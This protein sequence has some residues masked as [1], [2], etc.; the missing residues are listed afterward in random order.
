MFFDTVF[1]RYCRVNYFRTIIRCAIFE[2][3]SP[4]NNLNNTLHVVLFRDAPIDDG[5]QM[6]KRKATTEYAQYIPCFLVF[7]LLLQI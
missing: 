3:F 7:S 6:Q 2:I 1:S 4:Y 5:K